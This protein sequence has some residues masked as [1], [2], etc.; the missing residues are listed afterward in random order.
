MAPKLKPGTR[1]CQCAACGR[2]FGGVAAFD[3][4]R[5]GPMNNR[6]CADPASLVTKRGGKRKLWLNDRGYWVG[7]YPETAVRA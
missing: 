1:F 3:M 7:D 4:H 2:Y 6:K 5:V